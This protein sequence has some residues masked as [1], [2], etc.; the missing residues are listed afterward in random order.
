MT[1]RYTDSNESKINTQYEKTFLDIETRLTQ[2]IQWIGG[3]KFRWNSNDLSSSRQTSQS[4]SFMK[5]WT[6]HYI[7]VNAQTNTILLCKRNF[8]G[9]IDKEKISLDDLVGKFRSSR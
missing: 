6:A 1:E 7:E 2:S 5:G 3:D 9:P 8:G 4:F